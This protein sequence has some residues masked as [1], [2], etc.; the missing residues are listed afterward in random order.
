MDASAFWQNAV[1]TSPHCLLAHR[2]LGMMYLRQ[3]DPVGAARQFQAGL[4]YG[5]QNPGL[6]NGLA[7]AYL[8][9]GKTGEAIELLERAVQEEPRNP[10]SHDNLGTAWLKAGNTA[11]AGSEYRQA[12][13]LKPDDPMI[14]LNCSYTHYLLKDIDSAGYY[15]E[16]AVKNGLAR[17]A[18]IEGRLKK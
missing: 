2:S 16:L 18:G 5:P 3:N 12:F 13:L 11:E 8:D 7:L 17:D 6:L 1:D 14:I 4:Q 10:F 9:L 15:Y